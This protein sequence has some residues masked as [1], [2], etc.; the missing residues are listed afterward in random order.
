MSEEGKLNSKDDTDETDDTLN[1]K[2]DM[3]EKDDILNAK[4]NDDNIDDILNFPL[5]GD[6]TPGE[7][8]D[9]NAGPEYDED[10]TR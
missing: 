5:D 6:Y 7:S 10:W 3:E 2:E 4:D 1:S 9:N 8:F